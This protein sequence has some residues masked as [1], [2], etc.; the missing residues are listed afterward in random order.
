MSSKRISYKVTGD[1]QGI[2]RYIRGMVIA[3]G[4]ELARSYTSKQANSIGVTGFVKNVSDGTVRRLSSH[5]EALLSDLVV[6][7]QVQGEAQGSPDAL[8]EFIGHLNTGPSAASV[9]RVEQS[10]I[11]SK[12]GESGFSVK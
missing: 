9:N 3:V 12:S 1:V 7:I 10:D 5:M 4:T 6:K 8:K 11:G 2:P